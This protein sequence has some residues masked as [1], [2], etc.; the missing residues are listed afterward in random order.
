MEIL[1]S[2]DNESIAWYE[3]DNICEAN[4]YFNRKNRK[5]KIESA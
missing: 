1:F 4:N 2:F 5:F 3:I